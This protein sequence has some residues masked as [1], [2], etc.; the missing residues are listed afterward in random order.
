MPGSGDLGRHLSDAGLEAADLIAMELLPHLPARIISSPYL[1]CV[2]TIQ[3]LATKLDRIVE[4][5]ERLGQEAADREVQ[6]F[7]N[8][9]LAQV[10]SVVVASH[11]PTIRR[12]ALSIL[13]PQGIVLDDEGISLE[14]ASAL[15]FEVDGESYPRIISSASRMG[16]PNYEITRLFG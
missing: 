9:V 13:D 11:G 15:I 2:E 6:D 12:L 8:F 16:Y 14:K 10:D 5:D 1:R 4:I 7:A 3:P